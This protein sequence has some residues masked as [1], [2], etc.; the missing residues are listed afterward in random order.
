[1]SFHSSNSLREQ[2]SY[3]SKK[4]G[5]KGRKKNAAI[6]ASR[7]A[8]GHN[9]QNFKSKS[10]NQFRENRLNK[11]REQPIANTVTTEQ[12]NEE[13]ESKS[14]SE[15]DEEIKDETNAQS[16]KPTNFKSPP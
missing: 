3:G 11:G 10:K 7:K 2:R 6:N 13:S 9:A 15:M 5:G 14:E 8:S 1:M 16:A 12:V 4:G